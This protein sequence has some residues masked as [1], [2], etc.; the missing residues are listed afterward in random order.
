MIRRATPADS[1]VLRAMMMLSNGYERAAARAMIITFATGWSVPEGAHE[2]WL[3]EEGGLIAAG[4]YALI[5]HGA[6]QELDLFFTDNGAQGTGLGRRLFDHM[7]ARARDLGAA[8]V[9]IS[10]NPEAAGFYRRMGAV[11]IGVTAPGDGIAWERPK[12]ALSL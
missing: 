9:V 10:S 1:E 2:V 6:D 12:L 3:A 7:T 5:P 4:F 8:R 11:D